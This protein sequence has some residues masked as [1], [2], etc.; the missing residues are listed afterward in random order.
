MKFE[1]LETREPSSG[2]KKL[3]TGIAPVQIVSVN[4]NKKELADLLGITED[5]VKDVSYEGENKIS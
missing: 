4:P 2:S 3:Y 1:E 5:K